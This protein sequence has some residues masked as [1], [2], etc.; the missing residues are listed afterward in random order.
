[1]ATLESTLQL[2]TS[3][4]MQPERRIHITRGT[5]DNKQTKTF[6]SIQSEFCIQ[7]YSVCEAILFV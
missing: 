2:T 7:Q 3:R 5:V 4:H 1:M 6:L